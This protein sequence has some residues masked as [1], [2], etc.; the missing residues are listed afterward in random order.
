MQLFLRNK[1]IRICNPLSWGIEIHG[2]SLN[3]GIIIGLSAITSN[4]F[5]PLNVIDL[6]INGVNKPPF[7]KSEGV[8]VRVGRLPNI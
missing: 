5:H 3:D 7:I 1:T 4:N 6:S 2:W 8:V